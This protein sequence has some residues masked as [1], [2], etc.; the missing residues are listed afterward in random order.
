MGP[1][2]I[3]AVNEI[4]AVLGEAPVTTI[5]SVSS[6]IVASV[7]NSIDSAV[8]EIQM[9][10]RWFN[11]FFVSLT[12]DVDGHLFVPADTSIVL[13]YYPTGDHT[14]AL[15]GN[16]LYDFTNS[17]DVFKSPVSV[18]LVRSL[19]F[20]GLPAP[21]R[22]GVIGLA[23]VRCAAAT[24]DNTI[25]HV[26]DSLAMRDAVTFQRAEMA[27]GQANLLDSNTRRFVRKA[28]TIL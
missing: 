23:L 28:S 22:R 13:P 20:D 24:G 16:R 4:L 19:P 18:R 12:P 7:V 3:S 10:A 21:V 6:P 25:I 9:S 15:N 17:T 1:T 14:L 5:D 11:T 26:A 2:K 27:A 8:D